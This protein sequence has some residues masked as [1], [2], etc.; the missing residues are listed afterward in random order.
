MTDALDISPTG[1]IIKQPLTQEE[2]A[3]R[4]E[5]LLGVQIATPVILGDLINYG[6]EMWP[7]TW[8]D[9][10]PD[11]IPERK[12][13]TLRNWASICNNVPQA[14]LIDG[15]EVQIRQAGLGISHLDAVRALP[16]ADQKE[17]LELAV[18]DGI[19]P[20]DELRDLAAARLGRE[21]ACR[22]TGT[23]WLRGIRVS[24][25]PICHKLQHPSFE[26]CPDCGANM[27]AFRT[28]LDAWLIEPLQT[29]GEIKEGEVWVSLRNT[30]S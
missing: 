2:W 11:W 26:V 17:L 24:R 27:G 13:Q 4:V 10:L 25:C 16:P 20:R 21:V 8:E 1:L 30:N 9:L 22:I 28:T 7:D 23:G 19:M 15:V 3:D 6:K 29:E 5:W 12:R 18:A 14:V